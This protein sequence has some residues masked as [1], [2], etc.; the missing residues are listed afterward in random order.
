LHILKQFIPKGLRRFVIGLFFGW[1][2]NY[3]T[4]AE[5]KKRCIGYDSEVIL[6]KVSDTSKKVKQGLVAYERDSVAFDKVEYSYPVLSGLLWIAAQ[7]NG[8]LN[9]LDFGGGLGSS[10]YQ[11]RQFLDSLVELNWCVVEQQHFV[12]EGVNHFQDKK[13]HFYYTIEEC[14]RSY[15]IDVVL[16]SSVLQYLEKPYDL[17]EELVSYKI[18]YLLID[19]TPFIE[20]ADRITIQRVPTWIYKASYPCWFFNRQKMMSY[21]QETYDCVIEFDALDKANIKSEFKGMLL[22][23]RVN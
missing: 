13:V 1:K 20:G 7:N 14:L 18:D 4:W 11:N 9:V 19:R 12:E 15:S 23:R 17:L 22:K 16:L 8:R 6:K 2:G 10:Y 3:S 21:L 5:A